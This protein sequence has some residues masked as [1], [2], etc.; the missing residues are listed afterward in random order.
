MSKG[1]DDFYDEKK[2]WSIVKDNLLESYL[3]I[4]FQKILTTKLPVCYIDFFA[5]KGKFNDGTDGSPRIALKVRENSLN[6]SHADVKRID[7]F[8]IDMLYAKE[9][10][11]NLSDFHDDEHQG[12]I[13]VLQGKFE[14]EVSNFLLSI[15]NFWNDLQVR[16]NIFLYIDPCGIKQLYSQLLVSFQ[17]YDFHSF[18]MLINFNSFGLFRN[19]CKAMRVSYDEDEALLDESEVFDRYPVELPE[20]QKTAINFVNSIAGADYWQP[21]VAKYKSHQIDGYEAEKI[22]SQGYKEFLRK[23]YKYVLD[24]PIRF[25]QGQR[26]KY[27]MVHVSNHEDGCVAMAFNMALRSKELFIEIQS[28]SQLSLFEQDVENEIINETVIIEKL[29]EQLKKLTNPVNKNI[30]LA[31]F[32]TENGVLCGE[33]YINKVLKNML[34]DGIIVLEKFDKHTRSISQTRAASDKNITVRLVNAQR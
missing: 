31:N 12:I 20:D 19:A 22:L 4:Y 21:I 5:G 13:R 1:N 8:F 10:E 27:R 15:S 17:K 34:K 2:P 24:M 6:K 9:L 3:T 11:N 29:K 16:P 26:P 32:Y 28:G 30:L 33:S 23:T 18:E 25:Q 7:A 14:D